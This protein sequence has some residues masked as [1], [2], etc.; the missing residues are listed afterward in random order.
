MAL[1]IWLLST[2]S[3]GKLSTAEKTLRVVAP[4]TSED[5]K[6]H[7]DGSSF[8]LGIPTPRSFALEDLPPGTDIAWSELAK[9]IASRNAYYTSELNE[10]AAALNQML[11]G[12]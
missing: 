12:K 1:V 7:V 8:I 9:K 6:I 3:D 11:Q 2:G 5:R 10:L 4:G